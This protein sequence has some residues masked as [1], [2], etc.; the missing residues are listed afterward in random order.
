MLNLGPLSFNNVQG[1]GNGVGNRRVQQDTGLESLL[2]LAGN[3]QN[4]TDALSLFG[5]FP[6]RTQGRPFMMLMLFSILSHLLQM[7][8]QLGGGGGYQPPQPPVYPPIDPP[9][10]PPVEPPIDPPTYPP[11]E[12]PVDPPTYPPVEPP[13]YPPPP[14]K[15]KALGSA[16]LFGDPQFQVFTP[17]LNL[18]DALKSPF[19]SG[20]G[21]G[22][23]VT[24]INDPDKGGLKVDV[25]GIQV[26]PRNAK[27]TGVGEAVIKAG[28]DT[29]VFKNNGDLLVNG[30]KKGNIK[31]GGFIAPITLANGSVVSTGNEID[32]AGGVRAERFVIS[33]GEYKITAALRSPHPD[34]SN[35]L[36][37]N[38]EELVNNAADNASGY[39]T[40]VP[41]LTD[42]FGIVDLLKLEPLTA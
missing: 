30:V 17:N 19:A 29:V 10:Y 9:T 18:P 24:L 15:P 23:T 32:G 28:T 8:S 6:G 40:S 4:S 13:V 39:Q 25:T 27:S 2:G 41:G 1:N 26:D 3:N 16:G 14:E 36:D 11:V 12:P 34:S 42:K 37:M 33:N 7:L 5:G 31:D 38:F 22:Q 35:F 21:N 20:I